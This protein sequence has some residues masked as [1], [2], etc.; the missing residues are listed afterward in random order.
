[1]NK[2]WLYVALTSFFELVWIFGFN[3]ATHWWHWILIIGFI[4]V[5]FHFLTKA[6]EGLPTGTVYAVFAGIGTMGTTLM[7]VLFF[8]EHISIEKILFIFILVMGV[9]G[10]KVADGLDEKKALRGVESDGLGSSV[11]GSTK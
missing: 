4:F 1:M 3:T 2:A 7:D 6:C 11:F 10:L 8:G 9:A 5:D